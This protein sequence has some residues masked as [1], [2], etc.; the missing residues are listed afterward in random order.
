V[1]YKDYNSEPDTGKNSSTHLEMTWR[2]KQHQMERVREI[3]CVSVCGVG[4][5]KCDSF[6]INANA[7][8]SILSAAAAPTAALIM[9]ID[10]AT[11]RGKCIPSLRATC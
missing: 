2:Q 6:S 11:T 4:G 3:K 10:S 7:P 9:N 5:D 1:L 8:E